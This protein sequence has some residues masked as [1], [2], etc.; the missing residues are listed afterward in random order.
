M[1][2]KQ[3]LSAVHW[4]T[5]NQKDGYFLVFLS[6]KK[7]KPDCCLL[8]VGGWNVPKHWQYYS[9]LV[10]SL[11]IHFTS[12]GISSD[13]CSQWYQVHVTAPL[14]PNSIG[15]MC[16][17]ALVAFEFPFR[18]LEKS[19]WYYS[20]VH[21][22]SGV[23][24]DKWLYFL[25]S[26]RIY[27][28]FLCPTCISQGFLLAMAPHLERAW[29]FN[30][31]YLADNAQTVLRMVFLVYCTYSGGPLRLVLLSNLFLFPFLFC[32]PFSMIKAFLF[33]HVSHTIHV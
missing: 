2:T 24:Q 13:S 5:M 15:I 23:S 16:V 9:L 12:L 6:E 30:I 14:T 25:S 1:K 18:I 22:F 27:K 11:H 29:L 10:Y 33:V 17:N 4:A 19:R 8:S 21:N 28:K 32:R 3:Q 26:Y 7:T 31:W 20:T